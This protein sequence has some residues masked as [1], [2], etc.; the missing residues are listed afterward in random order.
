MIL[1]IDNLYYTGNV[2]DQYL[3]YQV[4]RRYIYYCRLSDFAPCF[5][6][7]GLFVCL[8]VCFFASLF[9][10]LLVCFSPVFVSLFACLLCLWVVCL[11]C[12]FVCSFVCRMVSLFY[13]GWGGLGL[14][15]ERGLNVTA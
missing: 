13:V 1:S 6:F 5:S 2:A 14:S 12:L 8:F 15:R 10:C 7:V 3:F 4:F 9:V 11:F